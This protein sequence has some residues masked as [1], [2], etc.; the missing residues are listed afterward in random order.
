[1]SVMPNIWVSPS[2]TTWDGTN[3]QI[4]SRPKAT[5]P[6]TSH[7][8]MSRLA[9]PGWRQQYTK[10]LSDHAGICHHSMG[11]THQGQHPQGRNGA[12]KSCK[13]CPT[14][15]PQQ[16]ECEW[17]AAIPELATARSPKTTPTTCHAVQDPSWH[18]SS[19]QR[20]IP[21]TSCQNIKAH[22]LLQLPHQRRVHWLHKAIILLEDSQGVEQPP[23][24]R[25]RRPITGILQGLPGQRECWV[26]HEDYQVFSC[27]LNLYICTNFYSTYC[28]KFMPPTTLT[29][30][31]NSW[32]CQL[33]GSRRRRECTRN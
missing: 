28:L 10:H 8:E 33:T 25:S 6:C 26:N 30:P 29:K 23:S 16:I 4:T 9:A 20:A 5:R 3:T 14:L 27:T 32:S 21:H 24:H 22:P 15:I 19:Q 31:S 11:P 12:K 18:G 1:M 13:V 7:R 17:D 2:R